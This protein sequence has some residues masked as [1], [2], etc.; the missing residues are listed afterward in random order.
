[1]PFDADKAFAPII[2]VGK[3]PLV[4][5]ANP[6]VPVHNLQE[7]IGYAKA[8]PG[9]L[10]V[11]I[12]GVGAQAHLTME[13]L[14]KQ[15]GTKMN[16]VPYRGAAGS[17]ADLIA[18]Q[19]DLSINFTPGLMGSLQNGSL[20]GIAVTTLQRSKKLPEIPT[21][22]ESGFPGFESVAS[23]SVVAPAGTPRDI[24]VKLNTLINGYLASEQGRNDLDT[25]DMQP[26]GGTPEDLR[27]FIAGEVGKWGPIIR[28][29]GIAM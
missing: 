22:S 13:L 28:A 14:Q 17:G 24:V 18:G 27:D 5:A 15:A 6:Q 25:L 29:A 19:I 12:P 23:Y 1:M 21:V 26:S 20:R 4:L 2:L 9:K 3:S 8:N 16:Y 11:G 7:L 10:N